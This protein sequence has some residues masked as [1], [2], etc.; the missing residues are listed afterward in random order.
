MS[1]YQISSPNDHRLDISCTV[2]CRATCVN[3]GKWGSDIESCL[4]YSKHQI[5]ALVQGCSIS[6]AYALEILRSCTK[7]SKWYWNTM[8]LPW[9]YISTPIY[10]INQYFWANTITLV[11]NDYEDLISVKRASQSTPLNYSEINDVSKIAH[12]IITTQLFTFFL[13][14]ELCYIYSICYMVCPLI[15]LYYMNS[16]LF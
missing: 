4:H 9:R 8:R 13:S 16:W 7:P 14:Q 5:D 12:I 3:C 15:F 1:E 10:R 6:I 2:H 11:F